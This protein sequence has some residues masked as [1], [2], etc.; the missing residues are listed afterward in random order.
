M[1]ICHTIY[2]GKYLKVVIYH[3]YYSA[4]ISALNGHVNNNRP[5][6]CAH[7]WSAIFVFSICGIS[8][9]F[10]AKENGKMRIIFWE[11]KHFVFSLLMLISI[12]IFA[13]KH[14][15]QALLRFGKKHSFNS[16]NKRVIPANIYSRLENSP[17]FPSFPENLSAHTVSYK[18]ALEGRPV[19]WFYTHT[20]THTHMNREFC[21]M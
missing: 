20:H 21:L 8:D 3:Y 15:K 6:M 5:F 14:T 13:L 1:I 18:G 7:I 12:V 19:H 2:K 9:V 11:K 4:R 16:I 17:P 10:V